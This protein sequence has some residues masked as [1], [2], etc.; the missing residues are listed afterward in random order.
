MQEYRKECREKYN[1]DEGLNFNFLFN[2]KKSINS[3]YEMYNFFSDAIIKAIQTKIYPTDITKC[4][5]ACMMK[6]T[7]VVSFL[8]IYQVLF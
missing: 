7:G 8:E 5:F 2:I 4:Y 6:K 1:V 3:L